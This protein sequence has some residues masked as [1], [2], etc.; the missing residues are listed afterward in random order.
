MKMTLHRLRLTLVD[1]FTIAR[2]TITHQHSLI[3]ELRD[4]DLVGW[5]EVT[6]NDYYGHTFQSMTESLN[7][8]QSVLD[9]Y[10]DQ[11]PQEVWQKAWE[12][13]AGDH[14]ALA[15]LDLAA[16][17]LW[18]KR[19]AK[20][21]WEVWEL[22]WANIPDSSY[23]I[24]IDTI[25]RMIEK[26]QQQPGWKTYKIKLGTANDLE[27]V[28]ALRQH[29]EATFRVDANCGWTA[30]QTIARSV[31]L[32]QLGVE[33]IEQPLPA[34]AA[35]EDKRR[36]YQQS[37]LPVIADESCQVLADVARCEGLFHGVN[38][39]LCKCGGLTPALA[40]LRQARGLG[41]QTMV[42]CMVESS[43]GISAAAHLLPLLDYAD[44]DGA[45]LISDDPAVGVQIQRGRVTKPTE[46]GLG[47]QLMQLSPGP[48]PF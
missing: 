27:I 32:K 40:M 16:H 14:F 11:P 24:G 12:A 13:T 19:L 25:D 7:K 30:E 23:T 43:I 17:D 35:D 39:K 6:E 34:E 10:R 15:A 2:G 48:R 42:G 20:P 38:V 3:V 28:R 47:A 5:G 37:A 21:C 9:A 22:P 44:L 1:P 33:F 36:V 31:E 26:L 46:P 8:A 45:L 29:T 4:G 41:M 18:G